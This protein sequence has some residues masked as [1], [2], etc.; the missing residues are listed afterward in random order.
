MQIMVSRDDVAPN[1]QIGSR[2]GPSERTPVAPAKKIVLPLTKVELL[3]RVEKLERANGRLRVK[4]KELNRVN[5]VMYERLETFD[6][7]L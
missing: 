6:A 4:N 1:A 2:N 3:V 7:Q 5:E